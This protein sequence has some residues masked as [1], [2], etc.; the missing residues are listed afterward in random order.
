MSLRN[1]SFTSSADNELLF[2]TAKEELEVEDRADSLP[3]RWLSPSAI[4][5][6]AAS[7]GSSSFA[8]LV[9]PCATRPAARGMG[10][11]VLPNPSRDSEEE[12][13]LPEKPAVSLDKKLSLL[14]SF[15]ALALKRLVKAFFCGAAFAPSDCAAAVVEDPAVLVA[16]MVDARAGG[17]AFATCCCFAFARGNDGLEEQGGLES[18]GLH[19]RFA[20]GKTQ[21]S[22][23]VGAGSVSGLDAQVDTLF[24][25]ELMTGRSIFADRPASSRRGDLNGERGRR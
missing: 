5:S 14:S 16:V 6:T 25:W 10:S 24:I 11:G 9:V 18:D 8:V 17:S 20:R 7:S 12:R 3:L 4:V 15:C 1:F 23:T 19:F 13:S 21:G 22:L 2:V